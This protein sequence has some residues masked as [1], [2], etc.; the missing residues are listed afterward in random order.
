M[1]RILGILIL[2]VAF[3]TLTI[4]FSGT[5]AST[6]KAQQNQALCTLLNQWV[7]NPQSNQTALRTQIALYYS[8][9][10]NTYHGGGPIPF[11]AAIPPPCKCWTLFVQYIVSTG[12]P[13]PNAPV[14][15]GCN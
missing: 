10:A 3:V 13:N 7:Q 5:Q 12:T 15:P 1:K 8:Q 4:L 6:A 9:P 14:P 2:V 11:I